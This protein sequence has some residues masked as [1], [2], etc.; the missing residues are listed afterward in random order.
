[1]ILAGRLL[2]LIY[3]PA[4]ATV[5]AMADQVTEFG[6]AL[7]VPLVGEVQASNVIALFAL[8]VSAWALLRPW[9][10]ERKASLEVRCEEYRR[11]QRDRVESRIRYVVKNHGPAQ[12]RQVE[13]TFIRD[14]N[15]VDL[16][17][18]GQNHRAATPLLHPGEEH[19][20]NFA[21]AWGDKMPELV[22]VTWR[23]GRRLRRQR[24]EY[25]PS[26]RDL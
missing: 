23:D 5:S 9:W 22:V 21:G 17:L 12:A 24:Q 6:L 16:I 13:V 15:P 18:I 26:V 4:G 14:G 3:V 11:V 20:M 2:G 7:R 1:V 8:A 25:H 19:H 10:N